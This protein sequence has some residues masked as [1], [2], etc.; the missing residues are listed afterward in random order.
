MPIGF[1]DPFPTRDKRHA[2]F[3]GDAL[4]LLGLPPAALT[5]FP[6][7][8]GYT[9]LSV[10]DKVTNSCYLALHYAAFARSQS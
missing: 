10:S 2:V 7:L 1:M 6:Q 5:C 3:H 9:S 8:Q 4:A